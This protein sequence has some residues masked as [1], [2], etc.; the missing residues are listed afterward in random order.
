MKIKIIILASLHYRAISWYTDYLQHPSHSPLKEMI[1]SMMYWKG[2]HTPSSNIKSCRSCQIQ[3]TQPKVWS[4]TIK[5]DRNDY[6]KS[7][8]CTPHEVIHS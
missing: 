5:V 7:I 3:E 8:M 6:P 4:C 1:K 2:M